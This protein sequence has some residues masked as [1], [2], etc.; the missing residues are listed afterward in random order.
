MY[1]SITETIV[2]FNTVLLLHCVSKNV[3]P[4]AC[5]NF[6]T[7]EQTLMFFWQRCCNVCNQNSLLCHL[8]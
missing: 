7:C 4:L 3:P 1:A 5:Y 8:K 2:T 6:D